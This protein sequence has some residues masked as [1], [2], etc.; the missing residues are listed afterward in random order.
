MGNTEFKENSHVKST[1]LISLLWSI[2]R[3]DGDVLG[4]IS[5]WGRSDFSVPFF[6]IVPLA[7]TWT[8]SKSGPL[9]L[10][11]PPAEDDSSAQSTPLG[12]SAQSILSDGVTG[13]IFYTQKTFIHFILQIF[14]KDFLWARHCFTYKD[15][16][17]L[18]QIKSFSISVVGRHK[19]SFVTVIKAVRRRNEL[20]KG[21]LF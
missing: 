9:V 6:H 13:V 11:N 8:L 5:V 10:R 17:R 20:A 15:T 2:T 1:G 16:Q 14:F 7:L 18:R 12:K 19:W 4:L 3:L 21:T